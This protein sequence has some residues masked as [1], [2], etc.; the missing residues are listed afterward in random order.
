MELEPGALHE[1]ME[2]PFLVN[3][4]TKWISGI[5]PSPL[6]VNRVESHRG[7]SDLHY[8]QSE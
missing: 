2:V 3:N 6:V 4:Q 7:G 5:E 1:G 8:K